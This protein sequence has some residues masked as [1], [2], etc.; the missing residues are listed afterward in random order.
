MEVNIIDE[1]DKVAAMQVDLLPDYAVTNED[2]HAY[3][4]SWDGMLPITGAAAKTISKLGVTVYELT[5]T[6][7]EYEVKATELFD[8]KD[9]LF[10]VEKPD[11]NAFIQSDKGA[12]I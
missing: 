3:G 1:E 4:Y 2:M 7:N 6:D 12:I 5:P 9:K 8:D 11:W 10:G